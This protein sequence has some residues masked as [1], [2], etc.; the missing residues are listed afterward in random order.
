MQEKTSL[1]KSRFNLNF[2]GFLLFLPAFIPVPSAGGQTRLI[3]LY[4]GGSS[5]RFVN[6]ISNHMRHA[7]NSL[8]KAEF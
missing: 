3:A 1:T 4:R 8:T 5:Q 6:P 7:T 2:R